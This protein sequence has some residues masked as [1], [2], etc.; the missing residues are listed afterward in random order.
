MHVRL[1]IL[2]GI[3]AIAAPLLLA[4][5]P[6]SPD[7]GTPLKPENGGQPAATP[8]QPGSPGDD[9]MADPLDETAA[10]ENEGEDAGSAATEEAGGESGSTDTASLPQPVEPD[11]QPELEGEWFALFGR[12][13]LGPSEFLWVNG[14]RVSFRGNGQAF[15]GMIEEG[16]QTA[17]MDS[18][19]SREGNKLKLSFLA[20]KAVEI[21][22]SGVAPMGIGKDEEIG[23]ANAQA[24]DSSSGAMNLYDALID[25]DLDHN[26]LVLRDSRNQMYVYGRVQPQEAAGAP[27][28]GDWYGWYGRDNGIKAEVSLDNEQVQIACGDAGR[29]TGRLSGGYIIGRLEGNDPGSAALV[30]RDDGQL[31]GAIMR[32]PFREVDQRFEFVRAVE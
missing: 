28:S 8:E 5:C 17:T 32:K 20:S 3:I 21:G 27:A 29:F 24:P 16:T 22:L 23:L 26:Y 4:G 11:G 31:D 1:S 2:I 25:Y 10:P 6:K 13:D 30:L 18:Q 9:A 14:H 12:T 19:W 7:E 15:W